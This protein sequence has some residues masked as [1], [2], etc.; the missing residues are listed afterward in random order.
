[1]IQVIPLKQQRNAIQKFHKVHSLRYPIPYLLVSV[2]FHLAGYIIHL[3][4][5]TVIWRLFHFH[6]I[7]FYFIF[8]LIIIKLETE[9]PSESN[10]MDRTCYITKKQLVNQSPKVSSSILQVCFSV[11]QILTDL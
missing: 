8:P 3:L 9:T 7:L 4:S 1:M 2:L 11:A 5:V 6:L 10:N